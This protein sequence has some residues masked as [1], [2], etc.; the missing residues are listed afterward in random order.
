MNKKLALKQEMQKWEALNRIFH[1]KDYQEYL[2]PILEGAFYNSWLNPNEL[3]KEGRPL[4]PT[5]EAFHKAY[6]EQYGRAIAYKE[7]FNLLAGAGSVL[8]N[9]SKQINNP[10][11]NYEL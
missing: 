3:D 1:S 11:K 6:T 9:L 7:L 4:F 8:E 5:Q 2:K 10:E